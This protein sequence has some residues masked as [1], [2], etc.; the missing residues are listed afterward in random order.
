VQAHGQDLLLDRPVDP[1][2]PLVD[3]RV[4]HADRVVAG[5]DGESRVKRMPG[6]DDLLRNF[7]THAAQ[8]LPPIISDAADKLGVRDDA[9]R[10]ALGEALARA[11]MAGADAAQAEFAAQAIEQGVNVHVEPQRPE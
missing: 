7:T 5:P 4:S 1:L 11:Y 9:G 3:A 10:E 2:C 8:A 6:Y